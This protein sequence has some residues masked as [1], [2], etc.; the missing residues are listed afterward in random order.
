M[1]LDDRHNFPKPVVT[2][3]AE[4]AGYICSNPNCHK[5]TIGPVLKDDEKSTKTGVAAH[6]C[7]ASKNGPRYNE[8]QTEKERKSIK[9]AIWLC[10]TCSTLIDKNKGVDY[11]SILLHKWK[12]KHE[13]LIKE[14]LE[15]NK[16]LIIQ[17]LT[18]QPKDKG[19]A[20]KIVK[21]LEQRGVLFMNIEHEIPFYVFDSIKEIRTFL[22][23]V[24][25]EIDSDS[26]LEIIIDSINH[27]CREY[28]NTNSHNADQEDMRIGLGVMRKIIGINLKDLQKMYDVKIKSPLLDILPK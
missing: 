26:P 10:A 8:H 12:Y 28:M 24:Q 15:G 18:N 14:C 25:I 16:R 7:A 2:K 17:F 22:T 19:I 6:I 27:A 13:K 4:R 9:N 21:F 11:P 23:Q 3:I 5:I 1:A 20:R